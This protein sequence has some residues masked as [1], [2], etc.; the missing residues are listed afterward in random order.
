MIDFTV[1][2]NAAL[3][4]ISSDP[5]LRKKWKKDEEKR[6]IKNERKKQT[7]ICNVKKFSSGK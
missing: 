3:K 1:N 6:E 2:E 4:I 7:N 5:S